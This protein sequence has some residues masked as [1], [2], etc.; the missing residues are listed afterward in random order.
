MCVSV[1]VIVHCGW[2]CMCQYGVCLIY[3]LA[4]SRPS[5]SSQIDGGNEDTLSQKVYGKLS[6]TFA[7]FEDVSVKSLLSSADCPRY[8]M[9]FRKHVSR[10]AA[11]KGRA[12]LEGVGLDAST[13]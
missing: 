9:L 13:I 3:L 11:D 7:S 2:G 1:W 12:V 8:L 6:V 10:R 5:E 4:I